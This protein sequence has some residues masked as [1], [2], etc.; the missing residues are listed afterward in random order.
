MYH[1]NP[2]IIFWQLQHDTRKHKHNRL[3]RQTKEN[4]P[5]S[6]MCS[7]AD[8]QLETISPCLLSY[9]TLCPVPWFTLG[10]HNIHLSLTTQGNIRQN[11]CSLDMIH[12]FKLPLKYP[13]LN[14]VNCT[15]ITFLT[16]TFFDTCKPCTIR[17]TISE[18]C[19]YPFI[20]IGETSSFPFHS[21]S[22]GDLFTTV[23]G[24]GNDNNYLPKKLIVENWLTIF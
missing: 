14:E 1:A 21:S 22:Q 20:T 18:T 24:H 11:L 19:H 9:R 8:I 15:Q 4:R 5:F 17:G 6:I 2:M 12:I 3:I 10:M 16:S 7:T 13:E 23:Q